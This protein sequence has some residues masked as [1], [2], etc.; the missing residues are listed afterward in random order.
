V[1]AASETKFVVNRLLFPYLFDAVRLLER[2]GMDPAAIADIFNEL[3][4]QLGHKRYF[5]HGG[6]WGSSITEQLGVRHYASLIGIH[7][8][9]VPYRR[10]FSVDPSELSREEQ[11]FLKRGQEW[12]QQQGGYAMIQSTRP[13]TLSFAMNDSPSGLAAWIIDLFNAWCDCDGNIENKFSKDELLTNLSI[14]W[15]TQTAASSFRIYAESMRAKPMDPGTKISVP[16]A[17]AVF[18][19]DPVNAPRAFVERFYNLQHWTEMKQGG[20]FAALEEPQ[21]LVNDIREFFG[22]LAG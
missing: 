21:L 5:A 7:L 14:Y 18:P 1:V 11:D 15:F 9:D 13:Q 22:G 2:T 12:S 3:M 20:H 19:K 16:T 17:M 8:T 10:I 4:K 6:D